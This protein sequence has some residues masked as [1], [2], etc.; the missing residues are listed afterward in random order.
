MYV[1]SCHITIKGSKRTTEFKFVNSVSIN[2][3]VDQLTDS[4]TILLPRQLRYK[5]TPVYE[6]LAEGDQ[7]KVELGY[8]NELETVFQ[9]YIRTI[10]TYKTPAEIYCEDNMYLLKKIMIDAYSSDSLD[11]KDFIEQFLPA[12]IERNVV[13]AN[14]G[15]WRLPAQSL[16]Q[17]LEDIKKDNSMSFFFKS[18]K[19]YGTL[20]STLSNQ[21][22]NG[23]RIIFKYKW[24]YV[25]DSISQNDVDTDKLQIV[26]KSFK[27]DGTKLEAKYPEN[28]ADPQVRT[29]YSEVTTIAALKEFAKN[30]H[31]SFKVSQISGS[32]RAF[33]WPVVRVMDVVEFRDDENTYRDKKAFTVKSVKR[34]FG[35]N[36]Y[37]QE[38][39]ILNQV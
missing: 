7:V 2:S 28:I 11:I 5:Y 6:L 33:G 29:M 12:N 20:P 35:M 13:S 22:A 23:K 9:G 37:R 21:D 4:C 31:D 27:T 1:L 3:T 25:D 16:A 32:F 38:I 26:A 8:N 18:G 30:K 39:E 36:G 15:K 10:R 17:C 34:S 14:I 24:N 19:F